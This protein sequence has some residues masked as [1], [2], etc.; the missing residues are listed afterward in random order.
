[1]WTTSVRPCL[2]TS[3]GWRI[4]QVLPM[5][6][7]GPDVSPRTHVKTLVIVYKYILA[8]PVWGR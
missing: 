8:I 3:K 6:V 2:E 1:M 4:S 7:R 5:Q